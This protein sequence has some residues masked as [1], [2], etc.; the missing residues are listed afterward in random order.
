M[1]YVQ[2][3]SQDG[4]L[5]QPRA[6]LVKAVEAQQGE[7][8]ADGNGGGQH[9]SLGLPVGMQ[10]QDDTERHAER[11]VN[12]RRLRQT[13]RNIQFEVGLIGHG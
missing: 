4:M 8:D 3:K 5:A 1:K 7:V 11:Q 6:G 2:A 9:G 10:T 13:L 12:G